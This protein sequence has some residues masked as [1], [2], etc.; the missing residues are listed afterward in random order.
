MSG[1]LTRWISHAESGLP[2]ASSKNLLSA[3]YPVEATASTQRRATS[4]RDSEPVLCRNPKGNPPCSARASRTLARTLARSVRISSSAWER[5]A[6]TVERFGRLPW[7]AATTH[8]TALLHRM[9]RLWQSRSSGN[10][11]VAMSRITETAFPMASIAVFRSRVASSFT[12]S[13]GPAA[14]PADIELIRL[15]ASRRRLLLLCG[16]SCQETARRPAGSRTAV[17]RWHGFGNLSPFQS[18]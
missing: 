7:R 8:L 11:A 15:A 18:L 10:S 17:I 16:L 9:P 14:R 2:M 13:L 5:G 12:G 6:S 3:S 4:T 1:R